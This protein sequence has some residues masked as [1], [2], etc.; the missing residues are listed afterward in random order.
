[1][2]SFHSKLESHL[3][4]LWTGYEASIKRIAETVLGVGWLEVGATAQV[5]S[6]ICAGI[7]EEFIAVHRDFERKI[8]QSLLVDS[9]RD[10]FIRSDEL[11]KCS[12]ISEWQFRQQLQDRNEFL[13]II[14]VSRQFHARRLINLIH[15]ERINRANGDGRKLELLVL[16]VRVET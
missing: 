2:K 11:L 4:I 6:A 1:M 15:A 13:V 5:L 9:A 7:I 8:S 12:E 16:K 3:L 10:T 14:F